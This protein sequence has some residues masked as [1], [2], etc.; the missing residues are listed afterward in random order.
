[1]HIRGFFDL[2]D[3]H[4]LNHIRII[5]RGD[6]LFGKHRGFTYTHSLSKWFFF[7][8]ARRDDVQ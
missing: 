1:M 4:R 8:S 6:I 2:V 5:R 3:V 7:L